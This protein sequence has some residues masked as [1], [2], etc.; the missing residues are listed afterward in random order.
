MVV[1]DI[2]LSRTAQFANVVL[3]GCPSVEKDGTF[4]NTER[5]IQ[6]FYEV[7]PPLGNSRPDW[8]ILTELAKRMGHDWGYTHPAEIMD[9]VAGIAD[10]F[11]GVSYDRVQGWDSQC[12]PVKADGTD[13]PLLYTDGFN[14]EDG[15]A[16]LY[17]L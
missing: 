4:V 16:V 7:M 15:K 8:W 10:I 17:P 12:W 2:F 6:R 9:E 1:Q 3:P 13:T 5:R 11:K 14:M